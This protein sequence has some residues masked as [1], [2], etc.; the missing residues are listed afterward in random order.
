MN[1]C[2]R[3]GDL[4]IEWAV[5]NLLGEMRSSLCLC[6]VH[7]GCEDGWIYYTDDD[8][9]DWSKQC[10]CSVTEEKVTRLNAA[11]FPASHKP[12]PLFSDWSDEQE[13]LFD[14][15]QHKWFKAYKPQAR[16]FV[17][18]GSVGTGKSHVLMSVL[19]VLAQYKKTRVRY[20]EVKSLLTELQTRIEKEGLAQAVEKICAVPVLGL[21]ELTSE[22]RT[23]WELA[24]VIEILQT[25]HRKKRTTL[26]TTNLTA[27]EIADLF[28]PAGGRIVS[29]MKEWTP[30]IRLGGPDLRDPKNRRCAR[31]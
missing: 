21:D 6:V 29:R 30:T 25:R 3:C 15:L 24:A 16:G 20:A 23:E 26:I 2:K 11:R 9:Y 22:L 7:C 8:G 28:G 19:Q 14:W 4:G 10:L 18:T 5:D 1:G 27:D 31:G 17:L 12:T 13:E